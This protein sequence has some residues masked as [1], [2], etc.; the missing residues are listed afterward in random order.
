MRSLFPS[1]DIIDLF[2]VYTE[3]LNVAHNWRGVGIA[4]RLH[5][6]LLNRIEADH[7]NVKTRLEKVLTEWLQKAYDTTRFGQPSWQ[8][9]VTAVAHPAG[10]NNHALAEQIAGRHN[11]K[12]G[13]M[14]SQCNM[15]V[16]CTLPLML[17]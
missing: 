6:D 17:L 1:A 7:S 4:L 10:G 9:L 8:L 13:A 16:T 15:Y 5:P 2:D 11:G 12:W 3:L 14:L